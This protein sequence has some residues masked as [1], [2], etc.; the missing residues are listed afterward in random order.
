MN[1]S[2]KTKCAA[3]RVRGLPQGGF[4]RLPVTTSQQRTFFMRGTLPRGEFNMVALATYR[5]GYVPK[6]CLARPMLFAALDCYDRG[7]YIG[8]GV[9]LRESVYRFVK[10]ACDWYGVKVKGK[11]PRPGEYARALRDAKQLDRWGYE[12][13]LECIDAGNKLAH[14]QTV[15]S[16]TLRGGI[17]LLFA[18]MDREPY[19]GHERKPVATS[20]KGGDP[21]ECDDCD[22]DDRGDWWKSEGG[23]A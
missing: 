1:V 18:M 22:D 8:C 15:D 10:A 2:P 12:I 19:A 7:D 21:Y 23:A 5:L 14:C 13:V 11:H 17:A 4:H 16:A 3:A 6:V 20:Y 9:R